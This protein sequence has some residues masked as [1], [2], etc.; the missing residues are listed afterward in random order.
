MGLIVPHDDDASAMILTINCK[1]AMPKCVTKLPIKEPSKSVP[2]YPRGTS[3][4]IFP[5]K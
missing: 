2:F 1:Y 4:G 5:K 3:P